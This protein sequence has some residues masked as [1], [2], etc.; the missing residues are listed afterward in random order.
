MED[1]QLYRIVIFLL[2]ILKAMMKN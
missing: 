1:L 2:Y